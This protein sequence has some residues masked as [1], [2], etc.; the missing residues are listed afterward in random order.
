MYCQHMPYAAYG[1]RRETA[2]TE[3]VVQAT[4]ISAYQLR[5]E[6]WSESQKMSMK[7]IRRVAGSSEYQQK[8]ASLGSKFV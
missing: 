6:K 2:T 8:I 1:A 3:G 4:C 7:I 5:Y